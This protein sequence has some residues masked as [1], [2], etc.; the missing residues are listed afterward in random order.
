MNDNDMSLTPY[1]DINVDKIS[2]VSFNKEMDKWVQNRI[3][4]FEKTTKHTSS[5]MNIYTYNLN[6]HVHV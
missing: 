6:I 5:F 4:L 1:I 3:K 2:G